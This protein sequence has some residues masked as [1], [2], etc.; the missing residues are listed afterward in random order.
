[1]PRDL[2]T[3]RTH[4]SEVFRDPAVKGQDNFRVMFEGQ[5]CSP[6]FNSKGAAAAYLEMLQRGDRKPELAMG[7]V[8]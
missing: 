1:M 6:D 8:Q 2:N 5:L 7:R 4:I 3:G